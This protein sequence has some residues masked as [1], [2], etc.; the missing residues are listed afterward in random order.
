LWLND[1]AVSAIGV[2]LAPI[3]GVIIATAPVKPR[4]RADEP[5]EQALR[6]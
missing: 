1:R 4:S 3:L 2:L 6:G 5:M